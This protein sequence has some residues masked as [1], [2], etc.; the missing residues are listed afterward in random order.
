MTNFTHPVLTTEESIELEKRILITRDMQWNAMNNAGRSLGRAVLK[1]FCELAPLPENPRILVLM[2]KGHNT[3][4]ALLA[5]DEIVRIHPGAEIH[6]LLTTDKKEMRTFAKKA[7]DGLM[8]TGRS[9]LFNLIKLKHT[10]FDIVIDGLLGMQFHKPVKDDLAGVIKDVNEHRGIRFRAAVDLP[11]GLGD[12]AS[13]RADFTYA[14]GIAKAPLFD[15]TNAGLVGRIR[16]LDLG[17]FEA[18]YTGTRAMPENIIN[19]AILRPLRALRP[20]QSDKRS[21]GHLF[22]LSGSRTM[23]GALLMSVKAAAYS[24]AGLI[25]AFAPE[26]VATQFAAAVPEAMWVPWPET[27]S[28]GLALEGR[29]LLLERLPRATALLC[30]SGIGH[31][32]ETIQLV[33]DVVAETA[34]PLVLD[35]DALVPEVADA[36]SQRQA[37]SGAIIMTPHAGEFMRLSGQQS[38][39]YDRDALRQFCQSK[40][41][42]TVLKGP[43][44][45][46]CD[47]KEIALNTFGGPVLSRGGSGDLLA[48]MIG[49][50]VAQTP[51]H[52]YEAACRGVTWHGAAA[53]R[54]ARIKG[55][56]AVHTSELLEHLGPVMREPL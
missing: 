13:L 5:A 18:P 2:G 43:H 20:A 30:G 35:A 28:G 29:Q 26:S 1:D 54:M 46:V 19:P 40:G 52:A 44:T 32:P 36:A 17:F 39:V 53:D 31:E 42:I 49:G 33:K 22:V 6:V 27:P 23:P 7:F 38:P 51:H 24:G 16:Y 9:K 47:G 4:D 41:V 8:D 14:T 55:Q 10:P 3:G 15:P 11:S 50:L 25:T 45:R 56:I 48:G 37:D 12:P 34:L 21:F